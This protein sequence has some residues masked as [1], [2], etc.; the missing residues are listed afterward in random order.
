[1]RKIV[2]WYYEGRQTLY[3]IQLF[4]KDEIKLLETSDDF[5]G[6]KSKETVLDE[7]ERIIGFKSRI[8]ND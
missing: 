7:G 8:H 1:V 4:D 2:L 5:S 6:Y 3:G